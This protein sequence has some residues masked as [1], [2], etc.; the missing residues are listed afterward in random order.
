VVDLILGILILNGW[1]ES[2]LWVI[3]L[4]IGIDLLFHGWA[5]V[6]LALGVRSYTAGPAP[7]GGEQEIPAGPT[8]EG[9]FRA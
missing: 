8:P 5:W 6:L 2:S 3:G 7:G 9:Q 4:F 1:P